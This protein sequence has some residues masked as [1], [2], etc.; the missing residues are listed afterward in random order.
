[1]P[2]HP[3]LATAWLAQLGE[4]QSAEREDMGSNPAQTINQ[5]LSKT[6]K[7]MLGLICDFVSVQMITSLGGVIKPL[8]L[9]PSSYVIN[10]L[11]GD[12]KK[13]KTPLAHL[14]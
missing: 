6:G 2:V 10:N 7:I 4:L 1:M 14:P 13:A 8:D 5:R 11:E 3:T 9:Y 12:V